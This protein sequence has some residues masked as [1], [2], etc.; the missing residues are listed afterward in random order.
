MDTHEHMK[1]LLYAVR[2]KNLPVPAPP[3]NKQEARELAKKDYLIVLGENEEIA[4]QIIDVNIGEILKKHGDCLYDIHITDQQVYNKYPVF[5]RAR[6]EIGDNEESMKKAYKVLQA[7]FSLI[8]KVVRLK[9]SDQARNACEKNRKKSPSA[10]V[11]EAEEQNEQEYLDKL[12]K[13]K[14]EE[15][16]KVRKMTPD[17]RK[18]YEEKKKKQDL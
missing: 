8:D 1:S 7:I 3:S 17:Q 12:R 4:N 2:S 13:Q 6:L 14:Q 9:I 11:K 18:K 5:M 10:Q 16:D 15:A